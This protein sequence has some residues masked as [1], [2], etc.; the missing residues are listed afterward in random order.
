MRVVTFV[1]A[2]VLAST[3]AAARGQAGA[4]E[5]TLYRFTERLDPVYSKNPVSFHA[6]LRIGFELGGMDMGAPSGH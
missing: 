2:I 4:M 3:A 1:G 6:F 5:D